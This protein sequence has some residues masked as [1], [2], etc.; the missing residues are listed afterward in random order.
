MK[1]EWRRFAPIGLYIA[2]AAVF[3][4][5]GLYIVFREFNLYLQIGI[6]LVVLGLALFA[7]L[8]PDKLKTIFTGRQARYG[9]NAIVM[10][11]AF[12]GILAV[13]NYFVVNNSHRW[14][15]TE[16]KA[17]TLTQESLDTLNSL[18]EDVTALAFFSPNKPSEQARKILD[19]YKFFSNGKFN[20][21]F[22]DPLSDPVAAQQAEVTKDGTIVLSM[23]DRQEQVTIALEREITSALVRLMSK[24]GKKVY[25]L[26]GHGEFSIENTGQEDYSEAAGILRKKNYEVDSLNLLSTNKIPSDASVIVIPGPTHPLSQEEV[27]QLI[28]YLDQGGSLIVMEEPVPMTKF[29]DQEDLLANYLQKEWGMTL[30]H[31]I[32]VDTTSRQPFVAY[33]NQYG[34]HVIT[35]KLQRVGTAFPTARSVTI[36]QRDSINAVSLVE[37]SKQSWAETDLDSLNEGADIKPDDGV[38]IMGPVTLAVVADNSKNHSKIAVFGD[39]NFAT[40]QNFDFLGNGDL[41]INTIDWASGQ[42]EIINLTVKTPVQRILLP[43]EPYVMNLILLGMVFVLP[44]IMLV[45]G[46]IV[47][48]Q[49]KRR[50]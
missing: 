43:P 17:N 50:T 30:G 7:I 24:E 46:L 38:D 1:P 40:D 42:E 6:G 25:F 45:A 15:L 22:V 41:F 3:I 19:T 12:I 23:G 27:D 2:I 18:P 4:S 31:D 16:D 28:G 39:S 21:E 44:G 8:D 10:V 9:S 32:I 14:D 49:R 26:A 13:I 47:W 33:A 20:Y 37:T 29:G 34:N 36:E 5:A 35:D 48:I 11:V